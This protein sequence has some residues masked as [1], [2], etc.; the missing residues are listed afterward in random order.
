MLIS[1]I[2]GAAVIAAILVA[3]TIWMANASK[4]DSN[5][6]VRAVSMLYLDE[7]AG[8]RAQV[9]ET[10]IQNNIETIQI[11]V[12]MMTNE[13]L[14]D[15]AHRRAFQSRMRE[16]YHLERFAFVG[17]SGTIYTAVPAWDWQSPRASWN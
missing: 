1:V 2:I 6:A 3:G 9:V 4:Q 12:N 8:R 7:L 16:L 11:A 10:N 13:D 17:E 5:D 15:E 14:S